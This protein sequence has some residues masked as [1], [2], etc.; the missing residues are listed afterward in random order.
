MRDEFLR[1]KP[2]LGFSVARLTRRLDRA[3]R[4]PVSRDPAAPRFPPA[5]GAAPAVVAAVLLAYHNCYDAPF[6]FDDVSAIAE[7]PTLRS[8]EAA[9]SPPVG[10]SLTVEGRPLLNV[11]FALNR[12]LTGESPAGFRAVNVAIHALAALLLGGIVRR[13][14]AGAAR[15]APWRAA[16]GPAALVTALA[17][18][19]HPLQTESVTYVVQRAESLMG[20]LY[21]G[22]L[23][24]FVRACARPP[25]RGWFALAVG[26][27]LAATGVK[28]VAATAPVLLLL[29]DR[30]FVAGSFAGAWTARRGF[31]LALAATWVPLALQVAGGGGNR[32]GIMG[33][34]VGVGWWAYVT[35]QG[36]AVVRYL[37]LAAWP[38]PLVFEYGAFQPRPWLER[39]PWLAVAGPLLAATLAALRWRPVAGFTGAAFFL[40]LAPTSLVPSTTQLIVE[41]R[42]Y[43][44]LAA[45]LAGV[46]VAVLPRCVAAGRGRVA[47][48]GAAAGLAAL[49]VLTVA[50]NRTYGS[51]VGLWRDTVAK[52]PDNALA[53]HLLAEALER[54][55]ALDEALRAY[56]RATELRPE[57]ILAYG[58]RARL[59]ARSGRA[60]EAQATAEAALARAPGYAPAHEVLASLAAGAGRAEEAVAHWRGAVAAAPGDDRLRLELA[61]ALARSGRDAEAEAVYLAL[62]AE[63]PEN[64][65]AH[66]DLANLQRRTGRVAE[67][68][69][70]YRATIQLQPDHFAAHNNLANALA[71]AGDGEAAVAHYRAALRDPA[72]RAEV[73]HNLALTLVRLGR[74]AEAQAEFSAALQANPR[75]APAQAALEEL[76]ATGAPARN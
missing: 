27:V 6:V 9:W 39:L 15:P 32:S 57:F 44:P 59:L 4:A 47:L 71:A 40:L 75:F 25:G 70:G 66:F 55:G 38:S 7:N 41:H 23:Y 35:A 67:A 50:R 5:W 76:R 69:D 26:G 74:R 49:L 45:V 52:R 68:M 42:L 33:F 22:A 56:T 19:L 61:A 11:S 34:G 48:A 73:H 10:G 31:Y 58:G 13:T 14:L 46:V 65:R 16:A 21:L 29:Y 51:E 63:R 43:L 37:G 36:E 28:E 17:W 53:H 60:A 24:A 72:A 2:A 54:T 1:D 64:A 3:Q 18:A 20:C 12:W 8:L 62:R 30:T